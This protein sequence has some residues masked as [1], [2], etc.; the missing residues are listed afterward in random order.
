ME[1]IQRRGG[2]LCAA[3]R[4]SHRGLDRLFVLFLRLHGILQIR[5][6]SCSN[7]LLMGLHVLENLGLERPSKEIQLA[8]RG[9]EWL[10]VRNG[11]HDALS[12]T[13]RVKVL[14]GVGFQL[15]FVAQVNEEFLAIQGVTDKRFSTVFGDKPVNDTKTQRGLPIEI[16]KH[17][18]D[19]R[20]IPIESLETGNDQLRLALNLPFTSLGIGCVAVHV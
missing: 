20:M 11:K 8:N 7:F 5:I 14:L 4:G 10:M 6:V 18:I 13:I 1:G 3:T 16:R 2:L 9:H 12:A 19:F 17:F 15:P